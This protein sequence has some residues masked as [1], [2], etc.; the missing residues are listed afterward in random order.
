[1][2]AGKGLTFRHEWGWH[3]RRHQHGAATKVQ[4]RDREDKW[5]W[6]QTYFENFSWSPRYWIQDGEYWNYLISI[7]HLLY[8]FQGRIW[9]IWRIYWRTEVNPYRSQIGCKAKPLHWVP[10]RVEACSNPELLPRFI[11]SLHHSEMEEQ[12]KRVQNVSRTGS[13]AKIEISNFLVEFCNTMEP[14]TSEV[15]IKPTQGHKIR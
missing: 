9:R 14:K 13:K 12:R 10:S 7:Q 2:D 5:Q 1:M 11:Q 3:W 15:E 4:N 8:S 6:C